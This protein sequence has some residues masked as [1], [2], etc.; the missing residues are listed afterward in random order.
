M[1]K[2][3]RAVKTNLVSQGFGTANT[4]PNLLPFYQSI[5]LAGHN[6]VDWV[7][8]SGEPVYWDTN[9]KGL[10]IETSIDA[11]G[12]LGVVVSSEDEGKY[13][14]HRFWHL[15]E[16]KCQT[17]QVVKGGDLLG[18]ADSTGYST[19]NHLHRDLKECDANYNTLNHENG[20]LGAIDMNPFFMNIFIVDYMNLLKSQIS[21]LQK[22]IETIRQLL[23]IKK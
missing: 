8:M 21:I 11:N 17:G 9:G 14:K 16:F 10:V 1:L 5:D 2:I 22:I 6:G 23:G 20:Y 18:L 3:Y 7:A 4:K 15:K 13:Y 12:G 19:G